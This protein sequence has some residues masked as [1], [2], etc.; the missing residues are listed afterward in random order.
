MSLSS[1]F[2]SRAAAGLLGLALATAPVAAQAAPAAPAASG[3]I[4]VA[5]IDTE[6]ILLSS[7]AG[8]K[9]VADLKRLQ[10]QREKEIGARAA[11]LKDL[12]TKI[13]D[14]RLSLAQDKL[15]DLSKQYEEKEIAIRRAQDDATR[16][17]NKKRDEMLAQIDQRVMPV[18]NQVGKDLGYTLIFR[19]FESGLIYADEAIDITSVVIQ[20]LDT[21]AQGK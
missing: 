19:K 4:R 6:K 16:E 18:I 15:T 17:L 14:G 12:Q 7:V 8:K 20:R 9:V 13:N 5:V 21:A 10:E 3:L 2:L 1:H 11:E